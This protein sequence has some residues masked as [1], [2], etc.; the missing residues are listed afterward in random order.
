MDR[1]KLV[2]Y[3]AAEVM[4]NPRVWDEFEIDYGRNHRWL[5]LRHALAQSL[6]YVG[7]MFGGMI[8]AQ[9]NRP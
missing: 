6:A 7:V 1:K 5:R 4:R 9:V 3:R 2:E 8:P